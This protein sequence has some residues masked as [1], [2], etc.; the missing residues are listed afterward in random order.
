MKLFRFRI[1]VC[2][3]D[4]AYGTGEDD[5]GWASDESNDD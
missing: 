2:E 1:L 4:S 5:W 3:D